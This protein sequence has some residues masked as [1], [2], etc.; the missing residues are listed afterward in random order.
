MHLWGSPK[1]HHRPSHAI[2][3]PSCSNHNAPQCPERNFALC[4]AP[5]R[6][7]LFSATSLA[8]VMAL[9]PLRMAPASGS[10]LKGTSSLPSLKHHHQRQLTGLGQALAKPALGSGNESGCRGR[11]QILAATGIRHCHA[12]LPNRGKAP[13]HQALQAARRCQI[14]C[15]TRSVFF[16][17]TT[18][19]R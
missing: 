13:L 12:M 4:S 1:Q 18:V 15:D 7:C 8:L 11:P 6:Y 2:P 14:A 5:D 16:R 17:V 19:P 10:R 9:T 3:V